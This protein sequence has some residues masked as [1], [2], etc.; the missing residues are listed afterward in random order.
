MWVFVFF[1]LPTETKQ[2]RKNYT[3]FRKALLKDGFAMVQFS[4]YSRHCGSYENSIVHVNRVKSNLPPAGEVM[5]FRITDKQ[6]SDMEFFAGREEVDCPD[7]PQQLEM[8]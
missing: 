3:N 6:F 7:I 5:I 1:D 8:F 2:N 4:I